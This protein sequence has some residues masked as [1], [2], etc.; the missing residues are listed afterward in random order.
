M[1]DAQAPPADA[2]P[3]EPR[4]VRSAMGPQAAITGT[5]PGWLGKVE[6]RHLLGDRGG[7]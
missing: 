2:D 7:S 5:S 6:N 4:W 3:I 1:T